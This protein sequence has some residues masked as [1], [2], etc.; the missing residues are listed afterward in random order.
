M[1]IP[2]ARWV[3]RAHLH[4]H[5]TTI[6]NLG[7]LVPKVQLCIEVGISVHYQIEQV[8]RISFNCSSKG[9]Q[10]DADADANNQKSVKGDSRSREG[11]ATYFVRAFPGVLGLRSCI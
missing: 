6:N 5:L 9:S 7:G 10:P 1:S 11:Y 8:T 2:V 4:S 3:K